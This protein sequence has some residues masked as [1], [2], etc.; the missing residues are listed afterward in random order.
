VCLL[1]NGKRSRTQRNPHTKN[2]GAPYVA[3]HVMELTAG[4]M[5]GSQIRNFL[6]G[7]RGQGPIEVVIE[8]RAQDET[9][10]IGIRSKLMLTCKLVVPRK[11]SGQNVQGDAR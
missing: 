4:W 2:D 3:Q 11:G 10:V 9:V 7:S 5:G 6:Y 1:E 8:D